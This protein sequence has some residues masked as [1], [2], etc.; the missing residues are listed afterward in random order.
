MGKP[1]LVLPSRRVST[2]TRLFSPMAEDDNDSSVVVLTD[3]E[4]VIKLL[5]E[6]SSLPRSSL[7]IM[8]PVNASS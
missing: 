5:R 4:T 8:G 6:Q 3:A 2:T 1:P 7:V